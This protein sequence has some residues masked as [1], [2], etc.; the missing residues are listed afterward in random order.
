MLDHQTFHLGE[1]LT[2]CLLVLTRKAGVDTDVAGNVGEEVR[3]GIR[4]FEFNVS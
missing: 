3:V 2:R 1:D 4:E